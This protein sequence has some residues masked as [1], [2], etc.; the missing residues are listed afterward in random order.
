MP[1]G[2]RDGPS[3]KLQNVFRFQHPSHG[4]D[5]VIDHQRR[6]AHN[7]VFHDP[8]HIGDVLNLGIDTFFGNSLFHC[9]QQVLTFAAPAA[10]DF[11]IHSVFL[12][13]DKD[14]LEGIEAISN[15]DD[16]NRADGNESAE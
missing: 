12:H 16:A 10:K 1:G 6:G 14:I 7:A 4:H 8:G 11:D 2:P 5:P 9:F 15:D 3:E 13:L